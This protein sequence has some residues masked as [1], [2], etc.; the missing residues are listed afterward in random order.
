MAQASTTHRRRRPHRRRP[1]ARSPATEAVLS[2]RREC[3]DA[4]PVD[5]LAAHARR[6]PL[7]AMAHR[8]PL[9]RL[10]SHAKAV[11]D[12]SR[13]RQGGEREHDDS[14]SPA[15]P[16]MGP[17]PHRP[18]FWQSRSDDAPSRARDAMS[19]GSARRA[20]AV[21]RA[22]CRPMPAGASD[23]QTRRSHIVQQV[24][25][26]RRRHARRSATTLEACSAHASVDAGVPSRGESE[27]REVCRSRS[28]D[29]S[30][31]RCRASG[32]TRATR[33]D[34]ARR[35]GCSAKCGLPRL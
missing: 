35:L 24:L 26:A 7:P 22:R 15:Q 14:A 16:R 5:E 12:V 31:C 20:G 30:R 9:Q 6:R 21:D 17:Q 34:A 28:H 13:H 33:A 32:S 8:R 2:A 29:T 18:R 4:R 19:I 10:Q 27:R 23:R 3:D 11:H 1:R 25:Q